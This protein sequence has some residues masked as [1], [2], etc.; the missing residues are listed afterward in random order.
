MLP[1]LRVRRQVAG[2][3]VFVRKASGLRVAVLRERWAAPVLR[4]LVKLVQVR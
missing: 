4:M 1:V 3:M 2:R